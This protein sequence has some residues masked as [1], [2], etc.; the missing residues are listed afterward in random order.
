LKEYYATFFTHR[1]NL[2][3]TV[4]PVA[5]LHLLFRTD[6]YGEPIPRRIALAHAD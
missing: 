6:H 2:P 5:N 1:S 4:D 3:L